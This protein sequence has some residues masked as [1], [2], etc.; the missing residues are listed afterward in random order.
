MLERLRCGHI[1]GVCGSL[2][3]YPASFTGV[4]STVPMMGNLETLGSTLFESLYKRILSH[5]RAQ[6]KVSLFVN[7][8]YLASDEHRNELLCSSLCESYVAESFSYC[9]WYSC[10]LAPI[11]ML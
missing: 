6:I 1:T 4:V 2:F 8:S 11:C 9:L 10:L 7:L 5:P 3:R